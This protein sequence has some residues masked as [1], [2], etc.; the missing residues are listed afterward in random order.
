MN[1]GYIERNKIVAPVAMR[2]RFNNIGGW[3]TLTDEQR[4][5]HGWYPCDVINEGYDAITQIRSTLPEL[6][7]DNEAQRITA[8]YTVTDKTLETIKR[9]HKERITEDRY[10]DEVAGISVNG[11]FVETDRAS[12]TRIAQAQ[13]LVQLDPTTAVN[14]KSTNGWAILN[15]TNITEIA[16]AIGKH[17]QKCFTKEKEL[18]SLIDECESIEEVLS[19][20]W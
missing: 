6:V 9:E 10:E 16:L 19:I 12:Q 17:V 3:H 7:F 1:Y 18:H 20:T 4:A 14:W 11:Q 2:S 15:A 5:E 8:T 13:S